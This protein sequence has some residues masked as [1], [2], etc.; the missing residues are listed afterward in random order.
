MGFNFS[1]VLSVITAMF[2]GIFFDGLIFGWSSLA[3]VLECEGY[4][5]EQC[6]STNTIC[7]SADSPNITAS[8]RDECIPQQESLVLVASIGLFCYS[9]GV[10]LSGF[11]LDTYG[12]LITR[13]AGTVTFTIGVIVMAFS[14]ETSI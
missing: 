10:V 4:F 12:I 14:G 9:L 6:N 13:C 1:H 2:E 8:S 7:A 5:S 11:L 3:P